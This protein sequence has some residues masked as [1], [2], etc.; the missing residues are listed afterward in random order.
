MHVL[1]FFCCVIPVL[2][3][4]RCIEDVNFGLLNCACQQLTSVPYSN[5]VKTWV[6]SADFRNNNITRFNISRFWME[7]PNATHIDLRGNPLDCSVLEPSIFDFVFS[8]CPNNNTA[9]FTPQLTTSTTTSV[10]PMTETKEHWLLIT[11]ITIGTST[12]SVIHIL[13]A[14]C[15]VKKRQAVY[16]NNMIAL[17]ELGTV[18]LSDSSGSKIL[19]YLHE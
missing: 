3:A 13:A 16:I 9:T 19:H 12:A 1:S 4:S 7:F 18:C 5:S 2:V 15:I 11:F 6:I 17:E 8:D 14:Y 10:S